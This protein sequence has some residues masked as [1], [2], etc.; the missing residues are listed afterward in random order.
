MIGTMRNSTRPQENKKN[1]PKPP[2][3]T[4]DHRKLIRINA[5]P[6]PTQT[7]LCWGWFCEP[8]IRSW[9]GPFPSF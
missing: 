2:Q 7:C 4:G 6:F 5:I 1:K 3:A 9:I 8:R